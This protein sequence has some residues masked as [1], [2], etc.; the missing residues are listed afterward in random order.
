MQGRGRPSQ[1]QDNLEPGRPGCQCARLFWESCQRPTER[2]EQ[3][4]QR[5]KVRGVPSR[6]PECQ[7][8]DSVA[9]QTASEKGKAKGRPLKSSRDGPAAMEED[10]VWGQRWTL[11][12][13][14]ER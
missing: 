10:R 12:G 6:C 5:L 11:R 8:L 7:A 14:A 3:L 2:G 9:P 13:P 1:Q 4:P